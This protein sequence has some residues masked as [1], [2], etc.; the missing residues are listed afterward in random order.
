MTA[1]AFNVVFENAGDGWVYAHVPELPEVQT[2]GESLE[3]AREMVR[4]AIML[5]LDDRRARGEP[6]PDTGRA[7]VERVEIAA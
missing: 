5:V 2:Q 1:L 4:E 3:H 6:I 7:L